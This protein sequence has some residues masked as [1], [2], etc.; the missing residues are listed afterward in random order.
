MALF[1]F[2]KT[3]KDYRWDVSTRCKGY[4][5]DYFWVHKEIRKRMKQVLLTDGGLRS[6]VERLNFWIYRTKFNRV[7]CQYEAGLYDELVGRISPGGPEAAERQSM[8]EIGKDV[9]RTFPDLQF[10]SKNYPGQEILHRILS[11]VSIFKP[12]GESEPLGYTQGMN[13]IA[14][15]ALVHL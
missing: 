6:T 11:A 10:F 15:T 5:P 2:M 1:T 9:G 4:Q 12:K 7:K 8:S 13:F 3:R 14:G